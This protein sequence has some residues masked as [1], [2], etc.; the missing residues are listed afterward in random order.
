MTEDRF[1][2]Q[3][4]MDGIR[5]PD[6][7]TI[8]GV[9]GIGSWMSLAFAMAGTPEMTLIDYDTVEESNLCRIPFKPSDVEEFK[10]IAMA[11]LIRTICP[12]VKVNVILESAEDIDKE[13]ADAINESLIID[14]RDN[15][16]PIGYVR[17][18]DF[19]AGYEGFRVTLHVKPQYD[20]IIG[21]AAG[22]YQQVPS[23]VG[24]PMLIAG[25]VVNM[26]CDGFRDYVEED[27]ISFD[28]RDVFP[29]I[30]DQLIE[31]QRRRSELWLKKTENG[32]ITKNHSG[33]I[34]Q[35]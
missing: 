4:L 14:C 21:D 10:A 13:T 32:T 27:M 18:P 28:A 11:D 35:E 9:G 26:L 12:D 2:R 24:T 34:T 8:I 6:S 1:S 33:K 20:T 23:W 29:L 17:Q 22:G 31:R 3:K 16:L 7:I 5:V 25:A 15:V 30:R 19:K